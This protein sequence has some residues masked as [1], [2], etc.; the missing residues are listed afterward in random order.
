MESVEALHLVKE[1]ITQGMRGPVSIRGNDSPLF[2]LYNIIGKLTGKFQDV[3]IKAIDDVTFSVK[4]G[5]IFGLLGPNGSGKTTLLS[6]LSGLTFPTR[7]E[8]RVEGLDVVRDHD[9]LPDVMMYIPGPSFAMFF[10]DYSFTVKEN[11]IRYAE[12]AKV[13]KERVDE[14]IALTELN[15]WANRR[16]H[17]LTTGILARLTFAYGLLKDSKVYLMDEPFT[18]VSP[19][20]RAKLLAFI[21]E[22]LSRKENATVL[23][24]THRLDEANYLFDRVLILQNGKAIALDTPQSLMKKL[25]LKEHIDLEL[26]YES[27]PEFILKEFSNLSGIVAVQHNID[28]TNEVLK[29]KMTVENSRS[30]IPKIIDVIKQTND[31]LL[32]IKVTEPTLEDVYMTL[33][34]GWKRPENVPSVATCGLVR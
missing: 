30:T 18:G 29:V 24:A 6:M 3:I 22:V 8:A 9:K 12:I 25:E 1:Y 34:K 15:E 13:R 26:K 20:V 23:Y 2:F 19:E 21:K 10:S 5:E 27:N 11:L 17:E 31:R 4:R 7:G 28:S 14:V 33:S 32:Y 16:L